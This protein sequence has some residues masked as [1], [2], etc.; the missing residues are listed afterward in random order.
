MADGVLQEL[1]PER[2][3]YRPH[4]ADLKEVKVPREPAGSG[5]LV[6]A[7]GAG[8]FLLGLI[9][10]RGS[11][12]LL[13]AV[14]TAAICHELAQ[15]GWPRRRR[16]TFRGDFGR[17][18]V[19]SHDSIKV[20]GAVTVNRDREIVYR[21]WRHLANLPRF[22]THVKSVTE[23]SQTRSRWVTA[24]PLSPGWTEV[25][26][27]WNADIINEKEGELI[28]W[29]SVGRSDIDHA[30]SVRFTSV[31]GRTATDVT[32]VLQYHMPGGALGSLIGHL[33]GP[34][35]GDTLRRDL[36]EFKRIMEEGD[37]KRGDG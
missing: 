17:R 36:L 19:P 37:L 15:R 31:P 32:V 23:I 2:D 28:G 7:A 12:P 33:L 8:L 22:M 24:V 14:G 4:T 6:P 9:R 27:E 21:F 10:G 30:G 18:K 26:L 20:R 29:R 13:S 3:R 34:D 1:H 25:R 16:R 5:W 35:A 11:G